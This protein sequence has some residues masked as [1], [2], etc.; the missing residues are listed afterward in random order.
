MLTIDRRE[1]L[2]DLLGRAHHLLEESLCA[3]LKAHGLSAIEGRVLTVLAER[4]RVP[5]GDLAQRLH[6]KQ[7]TLSKVIDRLERALLVHRRTIPEDRRFALVELTSRGRQLAVPLLA[8]TRDWEMW[9]A[10]VLGKAKLQ[11]C[12]AMLAA[13][14]DRLEEPRWHSGIRRTPVSVATSK[15]R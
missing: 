4:D 14:V 1:T 13:V 12:Y 3:H 9:V 5:L 11:R 10:G 15:A 7:P 6:A 2:A 8:N